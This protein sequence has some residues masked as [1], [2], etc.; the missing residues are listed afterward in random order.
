MLRPEKASEL[1]Y[2]QLTGISHHRAPVGGRSREGSLPTT[3]V[4]RAPPTGVRSKLH[5]SLFRLSPCW[6]KSGLTA[7]QV[8]FLITILL[9]PLLIM[10]EKSAT[11]DE[12]AHLPAGY[13]YL[14]TG[15]VELNQ[16]H[17]PLIKE[18]C[19]LPLLLLGVKTWPN[20]QTLEQ[21]EVDPSYQWTY[22]RRFLYSQDA[23]RLLWWGRVPAVFL[24]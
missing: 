4:G 22:G 14:T 8:I 12:V 7:L 18:I 23:D 16:Q 11:Y 3:R 15:L 9:V 5:N 6:K 20:R 17:P 1:I 21:A 19:A 2:D 10:P 24:S 13:S